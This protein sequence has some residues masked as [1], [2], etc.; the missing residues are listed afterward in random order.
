MKNVLLSIITVSIFMACQ[1][2]DDISDPVKNALVSLQ[3]KYLVCDSVNTTV[4]GVTTK[5]VLGKGKGWDRTFGIYGNLEIY[6]SPVVNKYYQYQ[7]PNKI[8]YSNIDGSST[9]DQYFTIQSAT[10]TK[11]I[12]VETEPSTGKVFTEFFTAEQ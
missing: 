11:L 1:K 3:G 8:Y 12:L 7:S 10:N 4:N 5:Q 6:S 9:S 2:D